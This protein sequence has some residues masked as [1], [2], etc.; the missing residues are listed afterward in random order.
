MLCIKQNNM[1]VY[2]IELLKLLQ[3]YR[4]L[5]HQ[6][7]TL[8]LK[9]QM[10]Y[11]EQLSDGK[12]DRQSDKRSSF[13]NA[14]HLLDVYSAFTLPVVTNAKVKEVHTL[15]ALHY[16]SEKEFDQLSSA[17]KADL[18]ADCHVLAADYIPTADFLKQLEEFQTLIKQFFTSLSVTTQND[19]LRELF[20]Q[21]AKVLKSKYSAVVVE[22]VLHDAEQE[23]K[24]YAPKVT[25]DADKFFK[26]DKNFH[27]I[28]M[29]NIA[30]WKDETLH[31]Q[32]KKYFCDNLS[33]E[34]IKIF[35]ECYSPTELVNPAIA[36]KSSK[37]NDVN[38]SIGLLAAV[39]FLR[40]TNKLSQDIASP[41]KRPRCVSMFEF[42]K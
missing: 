14:L 1:R 11:N 36:E 40:N 26:V 6:I 20:S 10:K 32:L 33:F 7:S 22:Q 16:M 12:L 39:S 3:L 21:Q 13:S 15:V 23:L 29:T 35:K 27:V 5:S 28:E 38:K 30:N 42:G 17:A 19:Y 18:P 24:W 9:I 41:S 37:E 8:Q 2:M 34:A 25:F 31:Y 4:R